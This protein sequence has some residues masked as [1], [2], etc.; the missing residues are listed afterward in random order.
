MDVDFLSDLVLRQHKSHEEIAAILREEHGPGRGYSARSVR[1]FCR[2]HGLSRRTDISDVRL[3]AEVASGIA[4]LGHTYGRKT[5][6]GYLKGVRGIQVGESRVSD[7]LGR[8]APEAKR[9]RTGVATRQLNPVP[10]V[11]TYFGQK[12]HLDQNEKLIRYGVTHVVAIDGFSRKVVGFIT[13]PVKNAIE[14]YHCLFRPL[15][16]SDGLWDQVRTDQGREFDLLLFVQDLLGPLRGNTAKVPYRR[17][18]STHNL[19]AERFWCFINQRVNY[20]MKAALRTLEEDGAFHLNDPVHKF[21]V[22]WV[23]VQVAS[24]GV[25]AFISAWNSHRIAGRTGGR[26]EVLASRTTAVRKLASAQVPATDDAV[27]LFANAGGALQRASVYGLDP[28][29]GQLNVMERRG[30]VFADRVDVASVFSDISHG[31]CAALADAIRQAI[32]L[33]EEMRAL[34]T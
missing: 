28:L 19:R 3:D 25:M 33:T 7:S 22:S 20:P 1:R 14:I 6:Q 12:L 26:P 24:H 16:L 17:T 4:A 9:S 27:D 10:Y 31:G 34:A 23:A 15:L 18:Q 8:V 13:L 32:T 30:R 5:M 11:A 29:Q 2:L 21:C